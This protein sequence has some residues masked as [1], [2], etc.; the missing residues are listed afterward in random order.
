[1]LY[2]LSSMLYLNDRQL[3]SGSSKFLSVDST[4]G[5]LRGGLVG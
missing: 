2:A 4:N 1:M 3:H 5:I